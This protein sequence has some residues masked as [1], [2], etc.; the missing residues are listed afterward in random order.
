MSRLDV[1]ANELA[2]RAGVA[3][4]SVSRWQR[5]KVSN[6]SVASVKKIANAIGRPE[7]EAL[8]AAGIATGDVTEVPVS[9]E[10]FSDHELLDELSRRLELGRHAIEIL[11]RVEGPEGDEFRA[12]HSRYKIDIPDIEQGGAQTA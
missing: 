3:A 2:E 11:S 6:V 9:V 4:S 10:T 1:D 12:R 7:V 8:A 5:G